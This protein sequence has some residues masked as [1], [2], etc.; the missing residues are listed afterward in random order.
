M[1]RSTASGTAVRATSL[2]LAGTLLLGLAGCGGSDDAEAEAGEKAFASQAAEAADQTVCAAG[3]DV[4][5]APYAPGFPEA[6]V[7]PEDTSVYDV[8]DRGSTGV[9]VTAVSTA[10]FEDIL[11]FLNGPEQQAGF[12]VTGGETEDDDAEANWEADGFTGRWAIRRS[13]SCAGESV[14]QVLATRSG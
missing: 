2:A 5:E 12:K 7:F 14:I 13:G 1:T 6:W 10:A 11:A 8:E 9:I 3:A 4:L